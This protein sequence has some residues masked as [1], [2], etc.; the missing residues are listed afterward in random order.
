[1]CIQPIFLARNGH[2]RPFSEIPKANIYGYFYE[3]TTSTKNPRNFFLALIYVSGK[4]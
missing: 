4:E 3:E 1:M 2:E